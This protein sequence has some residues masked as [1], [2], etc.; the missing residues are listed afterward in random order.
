MNHD[1]V[2][3]GEDTLQEFERA[4]HDLIVVL[5]GNAFEAREN[6]R[7][8][9]GKNIVL[10]SFDVDLQ[11]IDL[12]RL[13]EL[14][15]ARERDDG[16]TVG[17]GGIYSQYVIERAGANRLHVPLAE[18]RAQSHFA[19]NYI[20]RAGTGDVGFEVFEILGKGLE[21]DY[22]AAAVAA[23]HLN[24]EETDVGAGIDNHIALRGAIKITSVNILQPY[25]HYRFQQAAALRRVSDSRGIP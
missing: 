1:F 16:D 5:H 2:S 6:V 12:L 22:P 4:G 20:F 14:E 8:S 23:G 17:G 19:A 24:G 10:R 25:L 13:C 3:G 21:S 9:G 15:Q 11:E 7:G 18:S